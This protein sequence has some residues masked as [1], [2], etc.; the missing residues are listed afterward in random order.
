MPGADKT[1]PEGYGPQTGRRLGY[2]PVYNVP[3]H[4]KGYYGRGM[5][6]GNGHGGYGRGFV[7][8]PEPG[9]GKGRGYYSPR[10]NSIEIGCFEDQKSEQETMTSFEPSTE[11]EKVHLEGLLKEIEL[12][13]EDVKKRIAYL[14][15]EK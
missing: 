3:G 9:F 8:R 5:G 14:K 7:R 6:R 4:I 10:D 11:E 2:C 13:L 1:G 15:K 12:E